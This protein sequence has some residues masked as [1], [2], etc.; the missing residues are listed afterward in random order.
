MELGRSRG[1]GEPAGNV[2]F[3]FFLVERGAVARGRLHG[4]WP[5]VRR[6]T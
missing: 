4:L 1:V 2:I 5:G 3:S 6:L